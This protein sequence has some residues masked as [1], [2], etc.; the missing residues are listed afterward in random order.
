MLNSTDQFFLL[1]FSVSKIVL[2]ILVNFAFCYKKIKI[3]L[4]LV[5]KS[6]PG[7]S[8]K[9][10]LNPYCIYRNSQPLRCSC[11]VWLLKMEQYTLYSSQI[12]L[13]IELD[14]V[15]QPLV[16]QLWRSLWKRLWCR[17]NSQLPDL[18]PRHTGIK[19]LSTFPPL[20]MQGSHT[21]IRC[22][23]SLFC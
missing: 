9:P 15:K 4:S 14:F 7:N 3:F 23:H 1:N 20:T 17:M 22:N 12:Y 8:V 11:T 5:S 16:W 19:S 13:T 18:V 6:F 2:S 21:L 10:Q